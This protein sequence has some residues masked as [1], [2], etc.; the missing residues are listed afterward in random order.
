MTKIFASVTLISKIS[1]LNSI[2]ATFSLYNV[3]NALSKIM[4]IFTKLKYN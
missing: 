2:P 4:N 3:G 1:L